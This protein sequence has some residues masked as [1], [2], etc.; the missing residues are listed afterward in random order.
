MRLSSLSLRN[1]ALCVFVSGLCDLVDKKVHGQMLRPE[2]RRRRI[3]L[4]FLEVSVC[5]QLSI[6]VESPVGKNSVM[7]LLTTASG[8]QV[9]V[10]TT[11]LVLFYCPH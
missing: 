10:M 6:N 9:A 11:T 7:T 1:V 4:H 3:W 8:L 2:V 5:K